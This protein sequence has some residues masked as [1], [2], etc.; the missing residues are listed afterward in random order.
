MRIYKHFQSEKRASRQTEDF[1]TKHK[2]TSRMINTEELMNEQLRLS[3]NIILKDSFKRFETIAGIDQ[4]YA[5]N[6]IISCI[7]VCHAKTL[8]IVEKQTATVPSQFPYIPGLLAYREMPAMVEAY[9]KLQM[10]PDIIIVDGQGIAHPRRLGLASHFGLIISRPTIGVARTLVIGKVEH[11]KIYVEKE[12]CGFE[13]KTKEHAKPIYV[14][15]GH[16]I[17]PGTALRIARETTKQ[18]HKLPEPLYLAHRGARREM[19]EFNT[20]A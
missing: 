15:P 18:T 16:M 12:L 17:S 10:T 11:G 19:K 2:M 20:K 6:K 7:V 4:T 14:S 8:E 9:S 3:E 13:L 5:G 1:K